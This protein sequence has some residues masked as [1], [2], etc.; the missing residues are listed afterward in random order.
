M[1]GN[2]RHVGLNED[3]VL[4]AIARLGGGGVPP[5]LKE[6]ADDLGVASTSSVRHWIEKL[7]ES[8][9]VTRLPNTPRSLVAVRS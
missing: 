8:G 2:P 1:T 7:E 6:L 4:E 3:Q 9:K 5:T